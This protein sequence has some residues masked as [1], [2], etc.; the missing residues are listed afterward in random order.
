VLTPLVIISA[1][2]NFSDR[3]FAT[4]NREKQEGT[5]CEP[6]EFTQQVFQP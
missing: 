1:T 5:P 2:V 6:E 4:D 3:V